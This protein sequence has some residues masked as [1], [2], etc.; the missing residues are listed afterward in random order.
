MDFT[1]M[2]PHLLTHGAM[3]AVRT[4]HQISRDT[5]AIRA[6]NLHVCCQSH[7]ERIPFEISNSSRI[8]SSQEMSG[9]EP[10]AVRH[11]ALT[12][13][14]HVLIQS[15]LIKN[16]GAIRKDDESSTIRIR[17]RPCFEN[18][19]LDSSVGQTVGES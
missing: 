8:N 17:I 12:L 10:S 3:N 9:F 7:P 11:H 5:Q 15:Q 2:M 19:K 18:G 16:T 14:Q 6:V 1:D 13:V 4:D